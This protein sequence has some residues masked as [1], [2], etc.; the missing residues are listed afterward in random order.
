MYIVH[1]YDEPVKEFHEIEQV[2]TNHF[3][4]LK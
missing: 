2:L 3:V 4:G 1:L